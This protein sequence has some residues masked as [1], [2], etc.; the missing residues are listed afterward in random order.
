MKAVVVCPKTKEAWGR[1][2]RLGLPFDSPFSF[3][4]LGE[5]D[6]PSGYVG[7][8]TVTFSADDVVVKNSNDGSTEFPCQVRILWDF[9]SCMRVNEGLFGIQPNSRFHQFTASSWKEEYI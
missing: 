8:A 6:K 5:D 7:D 1:A 3:T 9:S 4:L 2:L